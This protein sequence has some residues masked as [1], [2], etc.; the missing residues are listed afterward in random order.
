MSRHVCGKD[1]LPLELCTVGPCPACAEGLPELAVVAERG[2]TG[3]LPKWVTD[4]IAA[5]RWYRDMTPEIITTD[6]RETLLLADALD[7]AQRERDEAMQVVGE[8]VFQG[9][10]SGL[11]LVHATGKDSFWK[12]VAELELSR[13]C[14]PVSTSGVKE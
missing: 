14:Q 3:P 8:M 13:R 5:L 7:K 6:G 1:G 12:R 2:I 4:H 9:K 11:V 10:A